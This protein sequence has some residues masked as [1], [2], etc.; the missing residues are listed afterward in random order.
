M[1]FAPAVGDRVTDLRL[2]SGSRLGHVIDTAPCPSPLC[3]APAGGCYVVRWD[4]G[5][6]ERRSRYVGPSLAPTVLVAAG[7]ISW[8][9]LT[10]P[11]PPAVLELADADAPLTLF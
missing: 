7:P 5:F 1:S 8:V 4:D 2:P 3:T 6:V 9:E 11:D 10:R